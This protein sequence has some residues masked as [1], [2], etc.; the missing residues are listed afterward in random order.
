MRLRLC[1]FV[2]IY[3]CFD[4]K[5][6]LRRKELYE[7]ADIV[8]GGGG[9]ARR[10]VMVIGLACS[11]RLVEQQCKFPR[12]THVWWTV[13]SR[14]CWWPSLLADSVTV[15]TRS[16]GTRGER[17]SSS[18]A[19]GLAVRGGGKKQP[20]RRPAPGHGRQ[21]GPRCREEA[22]EKARAGPA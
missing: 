17:G 1:V 9:Q 14:F 19:E 3:R 2:I 6:D 5:R 21:E 20:R 22:R 18:K 12:R 8:N 11:S 13:S 7:S 15:Y 16:A 4:A 10:A